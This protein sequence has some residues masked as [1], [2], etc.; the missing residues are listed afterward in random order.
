MARSR[1]NTYVCEAQEVLNLF[2][3]IY[4]GKIFFHGDGAMSFGRNHDART[5][6]INIF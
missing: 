3:R 5:I 2:V 4:K 6:N 1:C